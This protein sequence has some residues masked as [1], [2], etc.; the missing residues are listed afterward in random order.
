MNPSI[1]FKT[2]TLPFLIAFALA[3][4]GLSPTGR[5]VVPAPD[6]DYPGWNTAE[7]ED[8]LFSLTTGVGN[9]ANG[10][11]ALYSHRRLS[12]HGHRSRSTPK[13]Y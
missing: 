8:A 5:A 1:Q 2:T 13:Q 11:S 10:D 4:F 7:G 12:E 6:G 3:C 9:T